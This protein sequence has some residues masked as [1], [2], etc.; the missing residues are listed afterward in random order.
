[1]D[2]LKSL[3]PDY[4]FFRQTRND[5]ERYWGDGQGWNGF[6]SA[7]FSGAFVFFIIFSMMVITSSGFDFAWQLFAVL[8]V[9][10]LIPA[11]ALIPITTAVLL[12]GAMV[13]E[14]IK[15]RR[16]SRRR[17]DEALFKAARRRCDE[18]AKKK[19]DTRT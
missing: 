9:F 15:N 16:E 10:A 12:S 19:P 13:R 11:F 14:E 17:F 1:M 8:G 2:W 18:Q 5:F 7:W 4:W 6:F 3:H